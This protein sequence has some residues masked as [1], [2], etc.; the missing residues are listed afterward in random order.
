MISSMSEGDTKRLEALSRILTLMPV[1]SSVFLP[2]EE[3]KD[4]AAK[5]PQKS[6]TASAARQYVMTFLSI[7]LSQQ[8][9]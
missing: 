2:L 7:F 5:Y 9:F 1:H 8:V 6:R 3:R 4:A